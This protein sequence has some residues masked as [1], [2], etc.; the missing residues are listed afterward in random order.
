[1]AEKRANGMGSD[2]EDQVRNLIEVRKETALRQESR[3]GEK[4]KG[5]REK[6]N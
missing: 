2:L 6:V 5:R 1:M 3:E 4:G